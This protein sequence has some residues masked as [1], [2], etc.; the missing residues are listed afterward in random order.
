M[1]IAVTHLTREQLAAGLPNI[2]ASPADAGRLELIARR[3]AV[4]AREVLESGDLTVEDVSGRGSDPGQTRS[5]SGQTRVR[6]G[7]DSGQTPADGHP[8]SAAHAIAGTFHQLR[9]ASNAVI[10]RPTTCPCR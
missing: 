9:A 7:S 5:N 4:D 2:L 1:L 3:P 8:R 6:L 10:R